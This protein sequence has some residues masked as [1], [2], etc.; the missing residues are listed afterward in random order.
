MS[1]GEK[2]KQ[3]FQYGLDLGCG[4]GL[5]GEAF[6]TQVK[7]IDGVDLA[8]KMLDVARDKNIYAGLYVSEINEFLEGD[9]GPYDFVLA[10]DVF[11][12]LGDLENTFS[13]IYDKT[14]EDVLFCFS[15]EKDTG[16]SYTLRPTGRFAHS[17]AYIENLVFKTGWK[18]AENHTSSLRKEQGEW[19]EG[20][21]WFLTKV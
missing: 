4:T 11:A 13:L 7:C 9:V 20:N 14:A 10:A 6:C 17:V 16:E 5:G 15:T 8:P 19:I 12:Y 3:N 1:K 21:L 2:W 18:I